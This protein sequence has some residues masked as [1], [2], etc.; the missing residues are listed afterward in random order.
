MRSFTR[1][2]TNSSQLVLR[3]PGGLEKN[4]PPACCPR[5]QAEGRYQFPR[6]KH[7]SARHGLRSARA[8]MKSASAASRS[9]MGT[10]RSLSRSARGV[11]STAEA[12]K[13][14]LRD[15]VPWRRQYQK[16]KQWNQ[17]QTQSIT[18]MQI[19][20]RTFSTPE[21]L[22]QVRAWESTLEQ[23][24]MPSEARVHVPRHS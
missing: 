20:H 8:M 17:Q 15:Q 2:S 11:W 12:L 9:A 19:R 3:R 21:L 1:P 4:P 24:R 18:D 7:F 16:A 10:S 22:V 14:E 23:F 13:R 6:L 5:C